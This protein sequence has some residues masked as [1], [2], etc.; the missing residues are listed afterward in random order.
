MAARLFWPRPAARAP[1]V[2]ATHPAPEDRPVRQ[3]QPD[4]RRGIVTV[5]AA[6][7]AIGVSTTLPMPLFTDYAARDGEGA[8][9]LAAAFVAYAFTLIVTAP[10]LGGLSDRIG[11]KPCVLAG[12]VLAGLSTFALA[13]APGLVALAIARVLQGLAVGLIAGAATAW[14]AELA[15]GPEAGAR[16]AA[17]IAFG[18]AGSYGAGGVL[19]L[20]ALWLF[21]SG[22]AP[23]TFWLHWIAIALL[24]PIVAFLP[25]RRAR[26]RVAWLRN[27]AFPRG[28][29]ATT[30]GMI[31]AWG[32]TGVII[33]AIPVALAAQGMPRLG[34]VVIC[35]MILFGTTVQQGLRGV[36]PRRAVL[37]G[38]GALV[39]GSGLVIW[40]TLATSLPVL[41]IG[42]AAVGS[43][44]YGFLFVGGLAAASED[45]TDR[46]RAAA[47]FFLVAHIGFFLPPSLTGF[48]MDAVGPARALLGLWIGVACCSALLAVAILRRRPASGPDA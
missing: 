40:G 32:T 45:A 18:T 24:L 44:A 41:L 5:G 39:V 8:G 9:A 46:A 25:D 15:G 2:D 19:T 36:A 23:V 43:A 1:R 30:L 16:A 17:T 34:P 29:L 11:R 28:T 31:P 3:T 47:G 22:E 26:A 37:V 38:L 12:L 7:F 27:P 35:F 48:A 4:G 6:V 42:G 33:T 14:A 20:A 21:G 10:L 13:V